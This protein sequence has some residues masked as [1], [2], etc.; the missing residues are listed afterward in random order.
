MYLPNL[1]NLAYRVDDDGDHP[2]GGHCAGLGGA[3]SREN[4]LAIVEQYATALRAVVA[5]A[6]LTDD[7]WSLG[8]PILFLVHQLCECALIVAMNPATGKVSLPG[9]KNHD[10]ENMLEA[11]I[12]AGVF[13][14]LSDEERAWCREF[15]RTISPLTGFGFFG[16]F[17]DR[18][19]PGGVRLDQVW[20]CINPT[21]MRDSALRFMEFS[22]IAATEVR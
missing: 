19:L 3:D 18:S 16:R 20:C 17:A 21:A 12:A 9:G 8:R 22:L 13:D 10:L 4:R 15:V 11:V 7:G 5:T 1:E 14:V 6:E 2:G